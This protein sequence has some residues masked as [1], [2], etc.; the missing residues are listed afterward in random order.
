MSA[1][2]HIWWYGERV[3]RCSACGRV[4]RIVM[5]DEKQRLAYKEVDYLW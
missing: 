1:C 2:V 4:E 5:V 3:R